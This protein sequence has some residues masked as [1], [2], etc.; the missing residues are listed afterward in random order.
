MN[1]QQRRA[2]ERQAAAGH[3]RIDIAV[4]LQRGLADHAAGRLQTA[5][6]AYR[7]VLAIAPNHADAL[8]LLGV[9]ALQLGRP[10]AAISQIRRAIAVRA[11]FPEAH[12]NLAGALRALGRLT[13]AE[14]SCREALR[15]RPD[16]ADA[17]ANLGNIQDR[18]GRPA[19]AE[20]S[21]R[22]ALRL[23]PE[24]AQAQAGL[25]NLLADCGRLAE[26]EAS[27][28][29][30]LRLQPNDPETHN[31]LGKVLGRDGRPAE[32]EAAFR[33]VLR[34]RPEHPEALCH[35]GEALHEL[36][37]FADAEASFRAALRLHPDYAEVHNDLGITLCAM[38]RP[39]EAQASYRAALR[40]R[41]DDPEIH[42]NLGSALCSSWHNAEGE[43]C[44]REALR[45]RPD[46][47]E[48]HVNLGAALGNLGRHAEAEAVY[49]AAI[50]RWPDDHDPHN[51]LGMLLLLTGRFA[52]GWHEYEWRWQ[53][54]YLVGDFR[55]FPV[56]Q[57]NGEPIGDRTLLV[58]AEQGFGDTIQFC[59]Y[60]PLITRARI[61]LEVQPPL[62]RLLSQLQGVAAVI[63]RGDPLPPFDLHC[64]L[65]S[66]PR[67]F[68]TT[69]ET[70]PRETPYLAADPALVAAWRQ[71]LAAVDGLRV[72]LVW[73]GG[74]RL[75]VELAAAGR[76]RST[77]L[78]AMA[79]LADVPGVSFVSLQKDAPAAHP[80]PGMT[81]H[82]FTAELHDFVDTAA[83]IE[84]LDLAIGVDTAVAHLAGA[85]GKP[86]WLLNRFD[87]DWRWMLDRDDSPWYPR[88]RQFRQSSAGDWAGVML[89]VQDALR[90]L[91]SG[92]HDA[93]R[94][95]PAG[96]P[97][98]A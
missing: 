13:E 33:A 76:R 93:L 15:L 56:P 70:I 59:R 48:A 23:R 31:S 41:P 74:Q 49:R 80:P 82:D 21:Y 67:A 79:P 14:A 27:F 46:Y 36:R 89:R 55:K 88:L 35:L 1:R 2:A 20:A 91:A 51:N 77:T 66:L 52:E 58:H 61:I 3:P 85:L 81:L 96:W 11:A 53:T 75:D 25:G 29:H 73:T 17:H 92:E 65:L 10:D 38:G 9:I 68:G 16:F 8:H 19:D 64:P 87:T 40:L 37:R 32:A 84:C 94:R 83:L 72:G 12:N 47:P 45:R 98:P 63:A 26:A 69:R 34:L 62:V 50:Q 22:E 57:W 5:E 42:N 97:D 39:E 60:V 24:L 7:Q 86:V 95:G 71:R 78:E 28:R 43:A 6:A 44:Y 54:K 30:A 4:V 90:R 18:S